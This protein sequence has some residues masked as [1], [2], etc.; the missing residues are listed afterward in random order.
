MKSYFDREI[1]HI[2]LND[3][4]I[5][6]ESGTTLILDWILTKDQRYQISDLVEEFNL[7]P[8]HAQNY[9][10]RK[11][12]VLK[13]CVSLGHSSQ[14]RVGGKMLWHHEAVRHEI[15]CQIDGAYGQLDKNDVGTVVGDGSL[16]HL[17]TA[18]KMIVKVM[19]HHRKQGRTL[20][21]RLVGTDL[22]RDAA[23]R[24]FA[25]KCGLKI[26]PEAD[27]ILDRGFWL[28]PLEN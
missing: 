8:F 12:D 23:Y 27:S 21:L 13:A 16:K 28:Q 5:H 24:W 1:P 25:K 22:R 7:N 3:V 11:S 15:D 17:R 19:E 20:H 9:V 18:C 10:L 4:W 26:I 6:P 14:R 2:G